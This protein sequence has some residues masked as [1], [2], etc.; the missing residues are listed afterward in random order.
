MAKR[1]FDVSFSLLVLIL[2]APVMLVAIAAVW[3]NDRGSPFYK[4]PRVGFRNTDFRMLKIR[5]MRLHADRSGV[6][7][8]GASDDRITPVGRYIRRFKLDELSQFWNVLKG[9]MSVVGPRP[10]VRRGGVEDYTP[11][12]MKLLE[13]KPGI[14]DLSS[15]VFSD[16]GEILDGAADPDG[17]YDQIIR[18]WKSRLGLLYVSRASLS[19]DLRIVWL[20]VL[21]VTSKK[22]AL[23]EMQPLLRKLEA[24]PG[25]VEICRRQ[26][27]LPAGLP[28]DYEYE[29]RDLSP[30]VDIET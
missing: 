9:D 23:E 5:S 2:S 21:A 4:A 12:E 8:T 30:V 24:D 11:A 1:M 16:E 27:P 14:T 22:R 20:T 26:G 13:V 10:N 17:L 7:S 15:V 25:L 28:P 6:S 19:L 3:L 29:A 18:P